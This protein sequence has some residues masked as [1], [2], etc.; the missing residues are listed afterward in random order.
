MSASLSKGCLTRK[1]KAA[2]TVAEQFR[3]EMELVNQNARADTGLFIELSFSKG[4]PAR[5]GSGAMMTQCQCPLSQ[6]K[7]DKLYADFHNGLHVV[8]DLWK[9]EMKA[10]P[11]EFLKAEI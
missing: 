2:R 4:S 7:N 9:T 8:R 3:I 10:C 11:D 6:R 5:V 1:R